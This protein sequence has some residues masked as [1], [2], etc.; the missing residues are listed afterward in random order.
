MEEERPLKEAR[1]AMQE[2]DST[3]GT[4][5]SGAGRG[6][7]PLLLIGILA[8]VG[9]IVAGLFL[10][11]ISLGTRLGL[12]GNEN[13]NTSNTAETTTEDNEP[14]PGVSTIPGIIE[15]NLSTG[16]ATVAQVPQAD[17]LA[18]DTWKT[19]AAALPA[20]TTFIGDIYTVN[21]DGAAPKGQASLKSPTG[22]IPQT[23][24]VFG[25]HNDAWVFV[26]NTING[27]QIVTSGGELPQILALVQTGSPASRAMGAEILP[28]HELPPAAA[29]LLSEI[30]VGSLTLSADG[31]LAGDVATVPSGVYQQFIR[32]TNTGIVVDSQ[33]LNTL[34]SDPTLQSTQIQT[35][36]DKV[37]SGNYAGVN[38]DYQGVPAE[39]QNAFNQYLTDLAAALQAQNKQ[40]A[41]TL[42]TPTQEANGS[43]NTGGQ[44]WATIGQI[45]NIV[46]IQ[47]PVN[48]AAYTTS[49]SAEQLL[50]YATHQVNRR[51]LSI[52]LTAYAVDAIGDSFL[53][54]PNEQALANFGEVTLTEGN[55]ELAPGTSVGVAL[56]GTAGELAWDGEAWTYRYTYEQAGQ[57]H[58]VWLGNEAAINVRLLL[59]NRYN[60]RG[61]SVRGLGTIDNGDG[62]VAA[63]NNYL[64]ATNDTSLAS[65]ASIIWTV[66]DAA[67][68]IL[69]NQSGLEL[70]YAWDGTE[71]PGAY[72]IEAGF[73]QGQAIAS[74]G[75]LTLNV[76]APTTPTPEPTATSSAVATNPT[77]NASGPT[78]GGSSGAS[79]A[80]AN[81]PRRARN[82][83]TYQATP[84]EIKAARNNGR[85][86]MLYW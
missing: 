53:E 24:D 86:A 74:L 19:A 65:A 54:M 6:F 30:T 58:T 60:L 45:A 71:Q 29:A 27:D 85:M 76:Q 70:T 33:S 55:S 37:T 35:L 82:S 66:K 75:S 32:V 39:Q 11:P 52:L 51:K 13:E 42:S 61:A 64:S 16:S 79:T 18:N 1:D 25:W 68:S 77:P 63:I 15:L 10:P 46:Y 56:T 84:V 31:S 7:S 69:A 59:A 49:G 12:G 20:N 78:Y 9:L 28:T 73:A 57:I 22:A 23:L 48:P 43:W 81:A 38:V 41:V 44:N 83:H 14:A 17:F 47:M 21:Y 80:N 72:T 26:P 8:V 5:P 62:Y 34:L 3:G 2:N 50:D 36:V 4:S 40:L 67:G